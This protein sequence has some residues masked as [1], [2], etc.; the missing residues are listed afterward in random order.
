MVDDDLLFPFSIFIH[1]LI[2]LPQGGSSS[3]GN[4]IH[5]NSFSWND[6]KVP[7]SPL[8]NQLK[9]MQKKFPQ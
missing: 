4:Q 3:N 2:A 7:F 9:S 8:P 6:D 1:S 5:L